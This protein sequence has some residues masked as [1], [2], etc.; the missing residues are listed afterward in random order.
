MP[1]EQGAHHRLM[2]M[3]GPKK[4][5]SYFLKEQRVVIGRGNKAD[6]QIPDT[7]LSRDHLEIVHTKDGYVLTD[8]NSQNG[9]I[10]NK[11]KVTQHNLRE[12][13]KGL[14]IQVDLSD[15]RG[16]IPKGIGGILTDP[17]RGPG[18]RPPAA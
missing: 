3:T 8:L 15:V 6:I 9:V 5:E 16:E 11:D 1:T 18:A 2:I 13:D 10:V 14:N 4:G 17:P 12:G 7:N